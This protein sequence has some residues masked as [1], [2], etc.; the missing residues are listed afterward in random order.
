MR[1]F[2]DCLISEVDKDLVVGNLIPAL[3]TKFFNDVSEEAMVNPILFGDYALAD[4]SDAEAE[5]PR[6]Y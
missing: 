1:I 5:D 6:L 2:G 4:P 3:I